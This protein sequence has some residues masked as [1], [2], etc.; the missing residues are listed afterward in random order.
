VVSRKLANE[1]VREINVVADAKG[2][3]QGVMVIVQ[4]IGFSTGSLKA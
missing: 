2:A 4:E 3:K 1:L